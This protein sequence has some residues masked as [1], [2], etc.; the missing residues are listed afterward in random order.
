MNAYFN[1]LEPDAL[2]QQF[3]AHPPLEFEAFVSPEGVPAF[4]TRFD[5]LTTLDS[6]ARRRL[7]ALP[8]YR[9]WC[10]LLRPRTCFVGTTVSEYALFPRQIAPASLVAALK[11]RYAGE[12]PFLI[13][14]DVPQSSPFLDD[15]SN[16]HAR[17][18][19]AACKRAGFVLLEGQALAYVPIDFPTVDAYISRLSPGRRKDIRR[20][21]RLTQAL[22]IE[23]VPTGSGRFDMPAVLDEYYAL[24]LNVFRQSDIHF[25]LLSA[26]FFSALLQDASSGGI[27]FEYRN[28][29]Q[30][31][32][33]NLC[34]RA[35]GILIDKYVGFRYPEARAMNLYFISWF[36]NLAYALEHG[37]TH[38]VAGWTDPGIKAYLGA[39]FT[40]TRHA[41]H[42][43]NGLLRAVLQRF[44]RWFE[45]DREWH[46]SQ[47][48]EP[49]RRS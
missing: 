31:I 17:D 3:L 6:G 9:Y 32:G 39:Q 41:V 43:R 29:G 10:K 28:D 16:A 35:G 13:I 38:Y 19:L 49:H 48:H 30:L 34:F 25:D 18:L 15:A 11:V 36:H 24:Y 46:R 47:T 2:V 42:V 44:A 45:S 12:Y 8:L 7:M 5:L 40:F 21:L 26:D 14:K 20:K 37:L 23:S 22:Q 27:V 33:Y 1:L 4:S